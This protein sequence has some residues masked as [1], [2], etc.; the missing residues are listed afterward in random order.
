MASLCKRQQCTV[1]RRGFRQELDSWRH[2]LIHCV[3]K[4]FWN[5]VCVRVLAWSRAR[6]GGAVWEAS[7]CAAADAS[8]AELRSCQLFLFRS[9]EAPPDPGRNIPAP[10]LGARRG[11]APGAWHRGSVRVSGA[12]ADWGWGGCARGH[13]RWRILVF[14]LGLFVYCKQV[15][16]R[17]QMERALSQSASR[18]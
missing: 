16:S 8:A 11:R 15:Q 10:S 17:V 7:P 3:G 5:C 12:A 6:G 4:L 1:E 13:G 18:L 9:A 14:I 2:K